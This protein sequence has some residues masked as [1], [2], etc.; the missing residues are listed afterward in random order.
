[1]A[2]K[3]PLLDKMRANPKGD[4]TIGD[5]QKLCDQHGVTLEPPSGSSHYK[6]VSPYLAGHQTV[7]YK[8][9]IKPFYIT[10][11]VSMIDAH[12]ICVAEQEKEGDE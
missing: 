8:R 12:M 6:A 4:W 7:P 5:V 11:L 9:P 1:M 3:K 2:P 10:S